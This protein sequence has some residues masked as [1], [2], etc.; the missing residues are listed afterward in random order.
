MSGTTRKITFSN[1][2]ARNLANT[3][4]R[5]RSDPYVVFKVKGE[6]VAK[7][8]YLGNPTLA[9]C[10]WDGTFEAN[11]EAGNRV[12]VDVEVWDSDR[13]E[14]DILGRGSFTL[15][16]DSRARVYVPLSARIRG[17]EWESVLNLSVEVD[18]PLQSPAPTHT[19]KKPEPEPEAPA[20][21]TGPITYEIGGRVR[22]S[23]ESREWDRMIDKLP[24]W[25]N[26]N[27]PASEPVVRKELRKMS[28]D[29]QQV[30]AVSPR[31]HL[32]HRTSSTSSSSSSASSATST[33]SKSSTS[34]SAS[35]CSATRPRCS[36]C[37][38]TAAARAPRRTFAWP[39]CT[40]ASRPVRR[41]PHPR[42]LASCHA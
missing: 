38:R 37:A 11:V 41:S 35:S 14:D 19:K 15:L 32:R 33:S 2:E 9:L 24:E 4:T 5:S 10:R 36:K 29:E 27:L 26:V 1:V 6:E 31:H 25:A 28:P 23:S 39:R 18:P 7:T 40:A 13:G 8:P 3:D 17:R 20:S 21:P 22:S 12:V 34:A 16:P 30:P 42:P